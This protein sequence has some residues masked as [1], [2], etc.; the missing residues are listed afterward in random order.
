[1]SHTP[2]H[3]RWLEQALTGSGPLPDEIARELRACERCSAAWHESVAL[4]A[5][6]GRAGGRR[7]KVLAEARGI[8]GAPGEARVA[9]ALREQAFGG[10]SGGA[11]R[12]L[13]PAWILAIAAGLLVVAFFGRG[14]L[15]RDD[16]AEELR[17]LGDKPV[18][19]APGESAAREGLR[20]EWRGPSGADSYRVIVEGR[21]TQEGVW[22]PVD[23]MKGL[24]T[25]E[26]RP[27]PEEVATWPDVVRCQVIPYDASRQRLTPSEWSQVSLSR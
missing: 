18:I 12:R 3:E 6:L 20:F 16:P 27:D 21:M 5:D 22:S 2:D 7:R 4:Q 11:S 10:A 8:R 26:W 19:V 25:T 13:R 17:L 24:R 23:E 14:L 9:R 1:M 15:T